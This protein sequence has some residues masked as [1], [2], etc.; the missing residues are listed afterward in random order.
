[1][2]LQYIRDNKEV[3]RGLQRAYPSFLESTRTATARGTF[4]NTRSDV[5]GAMS[6]VHNRILSLDRGVYAAT[7]AMSG[8]T[9]FTQ[10]VGLYALMCTGNAGHSF[11]DAGM[12]DE[13]IKYLFNGMRPQK[14][15]DLFLRLTKNR[16]SG[17]RIKRLALHYIFTS[18][19]LGFWSI[20]YRRKLRTILTHVWGRDL[21]HAIRKV[22]SKPRSTATD[23]AMLAKHIGGL[24]TSPY[25]PK[26]L[27]YQSVGFILGARKVYTHNLFKA[28]EEAKADLE[29]GR[30]VLPPEV[31]D[32]IRRTYHPGVA[33]E[34]ILELTKEVMTTKQKQVAQKRAKKAKV[35]VGW[36][37]TKSDLVDLVR[38]IYEI[39]V[40]QV[41]SDVMDAVANKAHSIARGLPDLG[42]VRVVMDTSASM[43]GTNIQRNETGSIIKGDMR[44]M[45]TGY[46]LAMVLECADAEMRDFPGNVGNFPE[47]KGETN[48]AMDLVEAL[49]DEPDNVF[50]I[51]DGYENSPTGRVAEV[52]GQV[53][54]MGITTPVYHINP[55][56]A[57]EVGGT[58]ALAPQVVPLAV[59]APNALST[60]LLGGLLHTDV[61]AALEMLLPRALPFEVV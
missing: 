30:G 43:A 7:L 44:P 46:A 52:M 19:N 31:L 40:N 36:D 8:A 39:G 32:G 12:E 4:Y 3:E 60:A 49:M 25:I 53:R 56:T 48:L 45:V 27:L 17:Q 11:L 29:A 47:P 50:I 20:K 24:P 21:A 51:S 14:V 37:P 6:D 22:M 16:K 1:M 61:V 33:K 10:Q 58:R 41:G 35:D 18:Q 34:A 5:E 55:V 57:A 2:D 59:S 26:E 9:E 15:F 13:L 42:K 28:Y 54:D 38:H 23:K